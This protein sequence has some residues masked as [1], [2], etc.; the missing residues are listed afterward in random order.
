M[1][2]C[3]LWMDQGDVGLCRLQRIYKRNPTKLNLKRLDAVV[4][5]PM[6]CKQLYDGLFKGI[7][8]GKVSVEQNVWGLATDCKQQVRDTII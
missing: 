6:H 5:R 7:S 1:G 2:R 4:L 3:N 8:T